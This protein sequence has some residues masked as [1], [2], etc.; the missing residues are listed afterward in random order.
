MAGRHG[1]AVAASVLHSGVRPRERL[2]F[3]QH[4]GGPTSEN[5]GEGPRPENRGGPRSLHLQLILT[6]LRRLTLGGGCG[7]H[8]G[9]L[10]P[11]AHHHVCRDRRATVVQRLGPL[12]G[13][14]LAA[15]RRHS[16]PVHAPRSARSLGLGS[17]SL[18]ATA[19]QSLAAHSSHCVAELVRGK[20][21]HV[22][23][24]RDAGGQSG[25]GAAIAEEPVALERRAFP[26]RRPGQGGRGAR[27]GHH[28][29]LR[30]RG[31]RQLEL[32]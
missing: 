18:A 30:R 26:R 14:A 25:Y 31:G 1:I 5:R 10:S 22:R 21:A 9:Q 32:L 7:E 6:L 27:H 16:Q 17:A 28:G 11:I 29:G 4:R 2:H 20:E 3:P 12:Q 24:P 15:G 8:S 13:D 23:V 19:L